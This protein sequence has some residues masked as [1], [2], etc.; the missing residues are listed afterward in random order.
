MTPEERAVV[1]EARRQRGYPLH[2]PPHPYRNAGWYCITAANYEHVRIM[3]SPMRRSALEDRL[4]VELRAVKADVTGWV[5]LTN[6]YHVLAGVESLDQLSLALKRT[7]GITARAWNLEDGLTGQRKVW[8]KFRDRRI[9]NERHDYHALSYIH[10]NAVKHGYVDSPYD[11][12]WCSVQHYCDTLGR[13]WLRE[14]WVRHPIG[15]AWA[16]GD[17]E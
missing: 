16:Y 15:N 9:R 4:L 6:H 3:A 12:L 11:W 7:H 2:A 8:Y 1:V 14:Q 5:V 10:Y 17:G 13:E